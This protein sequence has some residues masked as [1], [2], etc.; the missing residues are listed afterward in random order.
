MFK[1]FLCVWLAT[2]ASLIAAGVTK[3]IS[4]YFFKSTHFKKLKDA[5]ERE[6]ILQVM[7]CAASLTYTLS[8]WQGSSFPVPAP[9]FS[10]TSSSSS[11][12]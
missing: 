11:F 7:A 4:T 8:R 9:S 10:F 5:L 1:V 3:H 12:L 2:C 6:F